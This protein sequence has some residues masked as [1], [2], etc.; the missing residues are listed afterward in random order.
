M[1]VLLVLAIVTFLILTLMSIIKIKKSVT[2][3][4]VI[5]FLKTIRIGEGTSGP[6]GYRTLFGG[7]VFSSFS[8]HP[9]QK[10][11]AGGYVS[12]AAG[13]YQFLYSTWKECQLA[14]QLSD[15]SPSNQDLAAVYL[16]NRR[17]ALQDVI[18]GRFDRAVEKCNQEWASL[19]GSPYGQPTEN[20]ATIRNKFKEFGGTVTA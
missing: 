12:T 11:R 13:A 10:I 18:D 7:G 1:F 5:A 6:D 14:L 8:D 4:N 17:G 20:L 16:I 2:D 9:N 3:K 15:F 19:P